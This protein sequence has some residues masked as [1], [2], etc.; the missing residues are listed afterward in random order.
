MGPVKRFMI[1]RAQIG[2]G[3][4]GEGQVDKLREALRQR[5]YDTIIVDIQHYKAIV[6][7]FVTINLSHHWE[8]QYQWWILFP[9]R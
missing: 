6:D 7:I 1:S 2:S 5:N 3:D 4:G 9:R 8:V